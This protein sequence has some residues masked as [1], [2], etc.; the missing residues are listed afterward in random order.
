MPKF[1][2]GHNYGFK[3]QN[4]PHN[5]GMKINDVKILP[6]RYNRLSQQLHQMVSETP[7]AAEGQEML[8]R[9]MCHHL[10]RPRRPKVESPPKCLNTN[11]SEQ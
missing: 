7:I 11:E 5:K 2:K 8:V 10:L 1:K 6:A 3:P 4:V 9:P